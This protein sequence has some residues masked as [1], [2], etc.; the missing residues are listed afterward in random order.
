M[1]QLT[2]GTIL[3]VVKKLKDDG[4]SQNDIAKIPIYIGNDDE[5]NGI[6]TAWFMNVIKSDDDGSEYFIEMINEDHHNIKFNEKAIL[7]S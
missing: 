3:D 4:M 1:K 5:L 6:H 7:I 2:M